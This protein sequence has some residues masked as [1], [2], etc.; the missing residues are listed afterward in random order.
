MLLKSWDRSGSRQQ[1]VDSQW[2]SN[3]EQHLTHLV[4]LRVAH[5]DKWLKSNTQRFQEENASMDELRRT[6]HSAVIDLRASI[7]LCK[8][9]CDDCNLLCV[10]RRL[11]EGHHNCLTSHDCIHDCTFCDKQLFAE[12]LRSNVSLV[13]TFLVGPRRPYPFSQRGSLRRSCV[14]FRKSFNEALTYVYF[15]Y[16]TLVAM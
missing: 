11:H 5:V 13:S 6:F 4:D 1:I 10:R 2:I 9:E 3:F 8:S 16:R 14:S 15:M 7:Q 12:K